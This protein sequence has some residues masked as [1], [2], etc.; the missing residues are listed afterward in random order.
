MLD[1]ILASARPEAMS[2][3][4]EALASDKGIHLQLVHSGNE[5]LAAVRASTPHLVIIDSELLDTDPIGLIQ[6]LVMVNAMVNTTVIS[7]L[8]EEEFHEKSEGLG[9]LGRLPMKP[10]SSDAAA[11]LQKLRRVLGLGG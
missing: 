1:I 7:P 10:S 11:L 3:F 6:K 4:L 5:A 9:V 2:A 8:S